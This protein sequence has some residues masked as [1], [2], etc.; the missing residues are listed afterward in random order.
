MVTDLSLAGGVVVGERLASPADMRKFGSGAPIS[1]LLI[2][3]RTEEILLRGRY[4]D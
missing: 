3:V 2:S 1:W 4:G